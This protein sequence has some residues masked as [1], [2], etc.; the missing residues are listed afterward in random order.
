MQYALYIGLPKADILP[1]EELHVSVVY[2][3]G[4]FPIIPY[5]TMD[6]NGVA[7]HI[8]DVVKI[9]NAIALIGECAWLRNRVRLASA[10]GLTSSFPGYIPHV[11]LIYNPDPDFKVAFLPKPKFDVYLGQEYVEPLK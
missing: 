10:L 6:A 4:K 8:Y 7:M 3:K 1:P 11:S 2:C 5:P 9:G